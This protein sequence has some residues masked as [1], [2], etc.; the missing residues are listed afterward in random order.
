MEIKEFP[1][2]TELGTIER[3]IEAG[4]VLAYVS[5]IG[6]SK[7]M[8][9]RNFVPASKGLRKK[10]AYTFWDNEMLAYAMINVKEALDMYKEAL[11]AYDKKLLGEP[12]S[13]GLKKRRTYK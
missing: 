5:H 13:S 8:E 10:K 4:R 6:Y 1:W 12:L 2:T 7:Y 3:V 11:E 9:A